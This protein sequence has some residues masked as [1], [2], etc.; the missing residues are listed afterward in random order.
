MSLRAL[1]N[2]SR[3]TPTKD[4]RATLFKGE[5]KQVRVFPHEGL[6]VRIPFLEKAY[7]FYHWRPARGGPYW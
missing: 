2:R 1:W 3:E 4:V 6:L 7:D 5:R